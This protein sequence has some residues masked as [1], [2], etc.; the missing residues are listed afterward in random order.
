[1]PSL[2]IILNIYKNY[3]QKILGYLTGDALS[4]F[5]GF[6]VFGLLIR[7][8]DKPTYGHFGVAQSV[9]QV[10]MMIAAA[11][12][13]LVAPK[14]L[15]SSGIHIR[16]QLRLIQKV[17]Y[18]VFW[19]IVVPGMLLVSAYYYYINNREVGFLVLISI[20]IVLARS[21]DIS[22]L[23]VALGLPG[24][25]AR[26]KILSMIMFFLTT[27]LAIKIIPNHIWMV[28]VIQALSL[29]WG[30]SML[31]KW[32]DARPELREEIS[33]NG[34]T[35]SVISSKKILLY[36]GMIVGTG[37]LLL[38]MCHSLDVIWLNHS[39][40]AWM[41]GE[42]VAI[43]RLYLFGTFILTPI[44]NAFV[45]SLLTNQGQQ[46]NY[47][48]SH[49]A[50]IKVSAAIGIV[51]SILIWLLGPPILGIIGGKTFLI[52]KPLAFIFGVSFLI[53]SV[54]NCY[55]SILPLIGEQK[56][57][58]WGMVWTIIVQFIALLVLSKPYG[59]VGIAASLPIA[60][61]FLAAYSYWHHQRF[62]TKIVNPYKSPDPS[63]RSPS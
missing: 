33:G 6:L 36:D 4:Y 21:M 16:K 62:I 26:S 58:M 43:G 60:M 42:Y 7:I 50:Y 29:I 54:G 46:Q 56:I 40:P 55:Y 45:P 25:L 39:H 14:A 44:L 24:P 41:V 19:G 20:I 12:M 27:L 22:Y 2:E 17:R 3:T 49:V 47:K 59:V 13:D 30:R 10:F 31:R 57:Y 52:V 1:M 51:G 61:S 11:G 28:I 53:V 18:H 38:L 48:E 8:I 9:Y 32:M 15:I 23:P 35:A 63:I 37:Q 34:P 5:I